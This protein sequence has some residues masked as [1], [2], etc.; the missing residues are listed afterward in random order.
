MT[1]PIYMRTAEEAREQIGCDEVYL[2]AVVDGVA[3]V[4]YSLPDDEELGELTAASL[5]EAF[6]EER[7]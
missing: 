2:L 3:T 7:L 6:A 5:L 4:G 1:D